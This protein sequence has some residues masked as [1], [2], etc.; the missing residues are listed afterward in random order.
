MP[1]AAN[2]HQI[3]QGGQQYWA[4]QQGFRGLSINVFQLWVIVTLNNRYNDL[5]LYTIFI[6][7][8]FLWRQDISSNDKFSKWSKPSAYRSLDHVG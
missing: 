5:L 2:L 4:L 1:K 6:F 8:L 3:V 7:S